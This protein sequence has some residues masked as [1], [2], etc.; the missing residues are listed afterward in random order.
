MHL[1]ALICTYLHLFALVQLQ[2][3][4][5]EPT[6]PTPTFHSPSTG[7]KDVKRVRKDWFPCAPTLYYP[8]PY[9]PLT[10]YPQCGVLRRGERGVVPLR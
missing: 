5:C 2:Y 3:F 1:F 10:Y 4:P 6:R 7:F 8:I 9:T